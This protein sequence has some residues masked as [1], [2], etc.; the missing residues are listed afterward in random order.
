M[1]FKRIGQ[2]QLDELRHAILDGYAIERHEIEK[3]LHVDKFSLVIVRA[4]A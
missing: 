1:G 4:R 3:R 2:S